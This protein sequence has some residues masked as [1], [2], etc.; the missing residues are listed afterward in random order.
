MQTDRSCQ[1]EVEPLSP[2][3]KVRRW[4]YVLRTW[5]PSLFAGPP[6]SPASWLTNK[7]EF[8]FLAF[9]PTG[10]RWNELWCDTLPSV[11]V[12][13]RGDRDKSLYCTTGDMLKSCL[14]AWYCTHWQSRP[15]HAGGAQHRYPGRWGNKLESDGINWR[16][17]IHCCHIPFSVFETMRL[18][19]KILGFWLATAPSFDWLVLCL[20]SSTFLTVTQGSIQIQTLAVTT[21]CS[22]EPT[23]KNKD[24]SMP[25]KSTGNQSS[26]W[27]APSA[28]LPIP[29]PK[30]LICKLYL[31]ST[32]CAVSL[33]DLEQADC[34]V[35]ATT[36]VCVQ[37][38]CRPQLCHTKTLHISTFQCCNLPPDCFP[39]SI[40]TG[41][42]MSGGPIFLIRCVV[43]EV[44]GT[45]GWIS[46]ANYL[47]KHAGTVAG[48]PGL[49]V[50]TDDA[51]LHMQANGM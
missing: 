48:F 5:V 25:V 27:N 7:F 6:A 28:L 33:Q 35:S 18:T 1:N 15:V 23:S 31:I 50:C 34:L 43:V 26:G 39:K 20:F 12:C 16:V 38:W 36:S 51:W 42:G 47:V 19:V 4:S 37:G 8:A 10:S 46:D 2:L 29:Q 17:I 49:W 3:F 40:N 24:N 21:S 13:S 32:F 44:L 22:S 41:F 14:T 30:R 9:F 45:E 11:V